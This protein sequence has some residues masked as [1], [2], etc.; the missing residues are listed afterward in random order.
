MNKLKRV[1]TAKLRAIFP[2]ELITYSDEMFSSIRDFGL[3]SPLIILNNT[4]V[5]GNRRFKAALDNNLKTV[6]VI[7][8]NDKEQKPYLLFSEL[9][10]GRKLSSFQLSWL[11]IHIEK[12][13]YADFYQLNGLQESPQLNDVLNY[14][15]NNFNSIKNELPLNIWRELA[16]VE[17][18][19]NKFGE[20]LGKIEGTISEKRQIANLLRQSYRKNCLPDTLEDA[21]IK[22]II[23]KLKSIS[24]PRQ[25]TSLKKWEQFLNDTKLPKGLRLKIDPTFEKP[26]VN[27]EMHITKNKLDKIDDI[28]QTLIK[29]FDD[30][31]EL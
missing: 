29:L 10:N 22:C 16:H 21:P 25:T 12:G 24:K 11:F 14:L 31:E 7:E 13:D 23:E 28:K 26:G 8:I 30:I 3:V 6:D 2:T 20:L 5:D 4:V 9:N 18:G 17:Q 27:L 15:G 1:E 19:L